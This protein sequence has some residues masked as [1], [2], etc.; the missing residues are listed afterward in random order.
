MSGQNLMVPEV[1]VEIWSARN[2]VAIIF[3]GSILAV[4][5]EAREEEVEDLKRKR[6]NLALKKLVLRF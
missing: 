1:Q 4:M 3:T 5:E 2:A 6:K